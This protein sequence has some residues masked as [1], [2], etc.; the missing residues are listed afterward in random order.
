MKPCVRFIFFSW[1]VQLKAP[2][3]H[4]ARGQDESGKGQGPNAQTPA[5]TPC[6]LTHAK[7]HD[8]GPALEPCLGGGRGLG[9]PPQ[10]PPTVCPQMTL[11][12]L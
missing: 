11:S 10:E 2:S 12:Y 8:L 1:S 3:M 6:H 9:L 5:T 7:Q 4:P